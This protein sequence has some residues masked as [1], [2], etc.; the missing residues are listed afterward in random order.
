MRSIGRGIS[1]STALLALVL[2]TATLALAAE[3]TRA[4]YVAAVEPICKANTEA[5][6]RIL[7]G[8]QKE[9]REGKLKSAAAR[10]AKAASALAQTRTELA[11]VPR[12]AADKARLS[13]WL[14]LVKGEVALFEATAKKLQAGDKAGAEHMSV[15]LTGEANR[16]NNEVLVFEFRYC[17]AEPS[18][19]M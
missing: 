1:L 18:R 17:R 16:A 5:N 10:F 12:P 14:G 11:A 15:R 2:L 8:V 4:E 3:T 13:R 6:K 19:F 7:A 9:V